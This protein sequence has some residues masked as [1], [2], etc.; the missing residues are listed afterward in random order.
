[1]DETGGPI[2]VAYVDLEVRGADRTKAALDQ[3][4]AMLDRMGASHVAQSRAGQQAMEA[5]QKAHD[6]MTARLGAQQRAGQDQVRVLS[7]QLELTRKLQSV[8]AT[9]SKPAP[10]AIG[11]QAYLE[12]LNQAR[13][14]AMARAD[15]TGAIARTVG[16]PEGKSRAAQLNLAMARQSYANAGLVQASRGTIGTSEDRQAN[17]GQLVEAGQQE[18]V[19]LQ[20]SVV[21]AQE[22][23]KWESSPDGLRVLKERLA[24]EE[25]LVRAQR[26]SQETAARRGLDRMRSPEVQR[27]AR[28]GYGSQARVNVDD[29][30]RETA[31]L[32]ARAQWMNTPDGRKVIAEQLR[33][34]KELN[35]AGKEVRKASLIA[36]HGALLGRWKFAGEQANQRGGGAG[37]GA[38]AAGGMIAAGGL[39]GMGM[40]N[41]TAGR[42]VG[43]NLQALLTEVA[44]DAHWS[45]AAMLYANTKASELWNG[46][47]K[48]TRETTANL[49]V[50][51]GLTAGV[52]GTATMLARF[53]GLGGM[54]SRAGM[55]LLAGAKHPLGMAAIAALGYTMYQ[56][57][58]DSEADRKVIGYGSEISEMRQRGVDPEIVRRQGA[59]QRMM[60]ANWN[61]RPD[62]LA[63][64]R[65]A[66]EKKRS[67]LKEDLGGVNREVEAEKK[68]WIPSM[69]R[70]RMRT[71]HE[72]SGFNSPKEAR[73]E[74]MRKVNE[75]EQILAGIRQTDPTTGRIRAGAVVPEAQKKEQEAERLKV[76]RHL[77]F[78]RQGLQGQT[79]PGALAYIAEQEQRLAAL[80]GP[81]DPKTGKAH[82]PLGPLAGMQASY[83]SFEDVNKQAQLALLNQTPAQARILAADIE[84]YHA[85]GEDYEN[86][87][88]GDIDVWINRIIVGIGAEVRNGGGAAP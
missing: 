70:M 60:T 5:A 6:R 29:T 88:K 17:R 55:G 69:F 52:L 72:E 38:A 62:R 85:V 47:P 73:E 76:E 40:R 39:V 23:A 21:L 4:K 81:T 44:R 77:G 45:I 13:A 50:I 42:V 31:S 10:Q 30:R 43:E 25:A 16:T 26:E 49:A 32:Q 68:S 53:L 18:L 33:A 51:G 66:V 11:N 2:A 65:E 3:Q 80:G 48:G 59:H 74:L 64:E 54:A 61:E 1:M 7:R 27:E 86:F 82:A 83:S 14:A 78:A 58:Q 46:L 20:R 79:S 63:K 87:S 75:Q 37:I 36:E 56:R 19:T 12:R 35:T 8:P 22:R 41:L 34:A 84:N 71:R 28:E 9:A 57:Q 15:A 24:L 67:E